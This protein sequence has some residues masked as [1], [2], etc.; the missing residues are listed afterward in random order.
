MNKQVNR[1]TGKGKYD[2]K[3]H[4]IQDDAGLLR[5]ICN[6]RT[7]YKIIKQGDKVTCEN[8]QVRQYDKVW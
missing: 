3:F 7:G 4:V 6:W 8:C 2:K 1:F 5:R